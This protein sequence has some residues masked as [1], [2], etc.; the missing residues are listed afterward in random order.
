MPEIFSKRA[1]L[2]PS[3]CLPGHKTYEPVKLPGDHTNVGFNAV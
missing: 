3:D 1:E 2:E